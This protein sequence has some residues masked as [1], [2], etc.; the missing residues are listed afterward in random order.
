MLTQA[1]TEVPSWDS[2]VDKLW[3]KFM[4]FLKQFFKSGGSFMFNVIKNVLI[5]F[6]ETQDRTRFGDKTPY[7][8]KSLKSF[9]KKYA[10]N[11]FLSITQM[12]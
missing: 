3:T 4:P 7:E 6:Q 12:R 2:N 9:S 10:Q 8:E 1:I 11:N 5:H